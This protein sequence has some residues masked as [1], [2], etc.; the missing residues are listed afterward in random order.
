MADIFISYSTDDRGQAA[1]LADFLQERGYSVWWDR[2]LCAGQQF[3]GEIAGALAGCKV[4]IVIWTV[5]SIVSRWV[6][7]E[8]E[9]AASAEKL[10]PVREDSLSERQLP[11]GFRPLHTIALSDR[12]GLLRAIQ[13]RFT[14]PPKPARRWDIAKM[15]LARR[16][17]VARRWLTPGNAAIA[18]T[19]IAFG[20]YAI[21]MLMNWEA[22][23]DSMEP[24]DFKQYA[25]KFPYSP[26]TTQALAKAAGADEWE[27]VKASRSIAELQAY[28]E[29]FQASVY[30]PYAHLRLTR[31]QAIASRKYERVLAEASSRA[32]TPE[33]INELDCTRLWTVRNEI[34][35]S[36]GYCFV[37][38]RGIDFFKTAKECPYR[39]CKAIQ[40][41]NAL[42]YDIVSKA[43]NDNINAI[44]SREQKQGCF[45]PPV[46]VCVRKE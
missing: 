32:L 35:F 41:F 11:I 9:T 45:V 40:K 16:L 33:E 21:V 36:L 5:S 29:K 10:I 39:N 43:E 1:E 3:Y 22:I 2:E 37:S 20:V 6:L 4:A 15:R 8:A 46:G 18:A 25:A 12:D 17:L 23:K 19:L 44:R 28:T 24:E 13:I 42:T 31:L 34:F 38:D 26:F 14:N 7:G 30:Y 27:T